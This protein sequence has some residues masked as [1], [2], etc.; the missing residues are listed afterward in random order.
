M[1]LGL[2]SAN[3]HFIIELFSESTFKFCQKSVFLGR[4]GR[5]ENVFCQKSVGRPFC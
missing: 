2:Y 3:F 5:L 4:L 1:N